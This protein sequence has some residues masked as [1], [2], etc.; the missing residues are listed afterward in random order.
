MSY[1]NGKPL[2]L[3]IRNK[4]LSRQ[5]NLIN[6]EYANFLLNVV[7]DGKHPG[8][9]HSY[10]GRR[11]F[12]FTLDNDIYLRFQSFNSLSEMESSTK[13]KCPFKIDIGP[14]YSVDVSKILPCCS[15]FHNLVLSNQICFKK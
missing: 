5:K 14:V 9:D 2:I 8:S 7:V 11:E 10:I 3:G 15:F 6:I 12:S 13:E 1:G 4:M